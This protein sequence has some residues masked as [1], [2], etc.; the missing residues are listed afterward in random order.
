MPRATPV[1]PL[2]VESRRYVIAGLSQAD[3]ARNARASGRAVLSRGRRRQR[4]GMREVT[5]PAL[6]RAVMTAFP[7]EMPHGVKFDVHIGLV[8]GPDPAEF[9]AASDRGDL[10]ADQPVISD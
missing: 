2:T 9:A 5:D 3:W 1:A 10:R 7:I 4:V 6:R 8:S